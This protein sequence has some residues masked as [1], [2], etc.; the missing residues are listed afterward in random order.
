MAFRHGVCSVTQN[1]LKEAGCTIDPEQHT[2]R[3][4]SGKSPQE[5]LKIG[6]LAELLAED[7]T[8]A[9]DEGKVVEEG[10]ELLIH[11]HCTS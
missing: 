5:L 11:L 6:A 7:Y 8:L 2:I 9:D 3:V 1:D 4:P 10:E